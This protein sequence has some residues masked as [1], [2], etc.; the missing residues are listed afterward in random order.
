MRF[1]LKPSDRKHKDTNP[2]ELDF[3]VPKQEVIEEPKEEKFNPWDY[4]R[5]VNVRGEPEFQATSDEKVIVAHRG[6]PILGNK[7]PMKSQTMKERDRVIEEHKKDLESDLAVQG[8][9]WNTLKD[10]A[11]DIVE[12]KQKVA[13][14]CFCSG[15]CHAQ[16]YLP[17]IVNMAKEL[18]NKNQNNKKTTKLKM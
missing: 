14:Q 17:V 1:S 7:H 18:I 8:P 3:S 6:N 13:L 9:I 10:I 5:V 12:N 11:R 16:N 4:I 2:E 15:N